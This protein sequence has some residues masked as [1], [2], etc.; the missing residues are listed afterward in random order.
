MQPFTFRPY[1]FYFFNKREKNDYED[2]EALKS[3]ALEFIQISFLGMKTIKPFQQSN[4]FDPLLI[5][6]DLKLASEPALTR[7]PKRQ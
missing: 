7:R 3:R 5:E 6:V 1:L 4:H 2:N